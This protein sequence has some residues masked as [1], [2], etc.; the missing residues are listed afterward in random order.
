M[1]MMTVMDC[2]FSGIKKA[3][4][5]F[6]LDWKASIEAISKINR[7]LIYDFNLTMMKPA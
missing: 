2:L 3:S 5:P 6:L 1:P 4:Q 7:W